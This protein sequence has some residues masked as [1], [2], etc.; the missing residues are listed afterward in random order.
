MRFRPLTIFAKSY[1]LDVFQGSKYA[2]DDGNNNFVQY[3]T[4]TLNG[5]AS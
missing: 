2:T 4:K 3:F 1:I 5:D